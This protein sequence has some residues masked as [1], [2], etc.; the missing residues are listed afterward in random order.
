MIPEGMYYAIRNSATQTLY[1]VDGNC[2]LAQSLGKTMSDYCKHAIYS[3]QIP[4][5][6]SSSDKLS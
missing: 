1:Y 5:N 2:M 3:D 4:I 6:G